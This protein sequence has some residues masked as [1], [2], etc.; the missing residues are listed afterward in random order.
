VGQ[1]PEERELLARILGKGL[2]D[3]GRALDPENDQ[4][5]TWWPP[6]RNMRQRNI[7]WRL[8][9]LFASESLARHVVECRVL[10]EI[11]TSDHAPV[12]AT[13]NWP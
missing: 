2:V 1:R 4:L 9:Y 8:D 6:W 11:G 10:G 12:I 7:G 3:V 13:I 5:F